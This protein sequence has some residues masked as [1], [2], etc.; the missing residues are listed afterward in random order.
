MTTTPRLVEPA[1]RTACPHPVSGDCDVHGCP[2]CRDLAE[3]LPWIDPCQ[4]CVQ[5]RDASTQAFI[6]ANPPLACELANCLHCRTCGACSESGKVCGV[7]GLCSHHNDEADECV[8][9]RENGAGG[10]V[11]VFAHTYLDPRSRRW[12]RAEQ[13]LPPH[14]A[15]YYAALQEGP[16]PTPAM[17]RTDHLERTA[18]LI[19]PGERCFACGPD[20]HRHLDLVLTHLERVRTW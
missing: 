17:T 16:L 8:T 11:P 2:F 19:F 4:T 20:A 14:V 1:A 6:A 3:Q 15:A 18:C 10:D 7:C 12:F 13:A 5:L 9:W